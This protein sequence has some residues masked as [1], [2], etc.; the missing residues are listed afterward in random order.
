[1]KSV[2]FINTLPTGGGAAAVMQQ[3][4]NMMTKRGLQT[5]LLTGNPRASEDRALQRQSFGGLLSWCR[6]RGLLDY[7][8]Q[9]S[10]A[11]A[12]HPYFRTADL[13]HLHNLHGDYFNLWSLPLLTAQKPTVWTLHDMW[14]LTGHCAHSLECERW[15]PQTACGTCPR[16]DLYPRLFRDSTKQLW[17]D[18]Q[19][20]Y[21]H[22][23]LY[24]VTPS[25][26]LQRLIEKSLLRNH[27][28]VCI[29]NGI[30]TNIYKPLNKIEARRRL[31]LPQDALIIGGCAD[32]GLAN[33]WKGGKYIVRAALELKAIFPNL[34]FLNIGIKH[35][36][37][38]L[39]VDWVHHIAYVQDNQKL[40]TIYAALDLLLY[41]T[42]ADTQALVC[43]ESLCCGTPIAGFA[44]GGI[45]ETVRHGRD[46][47]LAPTHDAEEF[48][49]NAVQI[50]RDDNLRRRMGQEGAAKARQCY[51]LDL[52][53]QRYTKV[54]EETLLRF[55]RNK[56]SFLSLHTVPAIIRGRTFLRQ[57]RLLCPQKIEK[58]RLAWF[59]INLRSITYQAVCSLLGWPLQLV[60]FA[61]SRVFDRKK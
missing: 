47:L 8:V 28:V 60:R 40:A 48:I 14:A 44:T 42:L 38:E 39:Q 57:Y 2:L 13:M 36:P 55:H 5:P 34:I 4:R 24:L 37:T 22:S 10:H 25:V 26:W 21:A 53:A 54:Y 43:V 31:C 59:N 9:K 19:T 16:L 46:G 6:W 23:Y 32:G 51:R 15:L 52:F 61:R 7:H 3:L 11:L 50:L 45:P 17:K 29:P 33:P 12:E 30:D 35:I 18:K 20:L 1:M 49:Q 58:S 56:K 27:S 41:P